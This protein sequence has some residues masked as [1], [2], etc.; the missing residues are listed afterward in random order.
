MFVL[1]LL[2]CD[3]GEGLFV[4]AIRGRGVCLLALV[5]VGVILLLC[6]A[7]YLC[8]F[9][10]FSFGRNSYIIFYVVLK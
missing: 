3:V 7:C 4:C 8:F 10:V 1:G 6:V 9:V 5:F 2:R